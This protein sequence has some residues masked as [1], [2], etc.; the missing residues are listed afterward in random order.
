MLRKGFRF[1]SF[2]KRFYTFIAVYKYLAY[3]YSR[4]AVFTLPSNK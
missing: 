4:R 1:Y 3:C 2:L